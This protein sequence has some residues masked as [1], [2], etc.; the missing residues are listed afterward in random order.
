MCVAGNATLSTVVLGEAELGNFNF[1]LCALFPLPLSLSVM[2]MNT[3]FNK[4]TP[5][6]LEV[7]ALSV[8]DG[9]GSR[10]ALFAFVGRT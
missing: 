1:Y 4:K 2:S 10:E 8:Q 6:D 5:I 9:G 3:F 7:H